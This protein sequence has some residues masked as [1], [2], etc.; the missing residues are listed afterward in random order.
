MIGDLGRQDGTPA[1]IDTSL[2]VLL[3]DDFPDMRKSLRMMLST[4]GFESVL[5]ADGGIEAIR[6]IEAGHVFDLI[7]SDLNMPQMSGMELLKHIRSDHRLAHIPFLMITAEATK[8][9]VIMAARAG[10]TDFIVKPFSVHELTHKLQKLG[11]L[12]LQTPPR[13]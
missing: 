8:P 7:I 4:L 6:M 5:A 11:G 3:V 9:N 1:L 12:H 2:R 10:V 13:P